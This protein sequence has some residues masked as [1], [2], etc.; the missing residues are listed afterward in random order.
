MAAQ[1]IR[2]PELAD[3]AGEKFRILLRQVQLCGCTLWLHTLDELAGLVREGQEFT[4][5]SGLGRTFTEAIKRLA[6]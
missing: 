3:D 5:K 6:Q 1:A 2:L 4:F